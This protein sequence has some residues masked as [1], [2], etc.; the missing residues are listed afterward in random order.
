MSKYSLKLEQLVPTNQF[1][2]VLLTI[3]YD[4]L[5]PKL[6]TLLSENISVSTKQ[7][8]QTMLSL[9]NFMLAKNIAPTEIATLLHSQNEHKD[10]TEVNA[11]LGII[12]NSLSEAPASVVN[13]DPSILVS[14]DPDAVKEYVQSL[15][16]S[17][18]E[19]TNAD[20]AQV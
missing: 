3:Q 11:I 1:G 2:D 17:V 12:G 8:T 20:S 14:V 6:V 10:D 19:N 15:D 4:G 18:I 7:V 13:L 9:V 16:V 5:G